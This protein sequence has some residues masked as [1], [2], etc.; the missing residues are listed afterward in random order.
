MALPAA[1]ISTEKDSIDE[2]GSFAK[3]K[4]LIDQS[5]RVHSTLREAGSKSVSDD[6]DDLLEADIIVNLDDYVVFPTMRDV[7]KEVV[8]SMY[9]RSTKKGDIVRV[10]LMPP[11]MG[12]SSPVYIIDG[13]ATR[14]TE[15]FLSLKPSELKTLKVV[16]N[17][18]KLVPTGLLGQFGL[19]IVES[20]LGNKRE[21]LIIDN[22]RIKGI[23]LPVSL[24]ISEEQKRNPDI[25]DFRSTLYWNPS[26]KTDDNGKALVEFTSS[27][28]TGKVLIMVDGIT[29]DLQ[30]FSITAEL[31]VEIK[32][33]N[34]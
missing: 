3:R 25:P 23:Q 31:M 14:N 20:R 26:I 24:K 30:P 6:Y 9:A 29:N 17:P 12:S 28:D 27:D 5:F 18:Q 10:D 1:P 33:S 16:N 32:K 4:Q 13:F 15:Y 8:P 19:V 7:I 34:P 2:Y 11:L 22:K 21:P